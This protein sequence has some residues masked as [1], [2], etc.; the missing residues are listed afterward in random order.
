MEKTLTRPKQKN[1][2]VRFFISSSFQ[3]MKEERE[4]LIKRVFPK[5]RSL[6]EKRGVTWGAVDLRW[7]ITDEQASE[8]Q[9]LPICLKEID[10][11][12]GFFIGILGD[13]Y[14]YIPDEIPGDLLIQEPWLAEHRGKSFTELEICHGV[15]NKPESA[16]NAFFYFRDPEYLKSKQ[17]DYEP[18]NPKKIID[19]KKRIKKSGTRVKENYR[20]PKELGELVFNDLK[21]LIDDLYPEGS[22]LD[23]LDRDALEHELYAYSRFKVYISRQEYYDRLTSHIE[24]E[25]QPLIV[26]GE[27]GS[28]KSALLAN[29]VENYRTANPANL[30][31]THYIGATPYSTDW[32]LMIRRIMGEFKRRYEFGEEIPTDASKLRLAFAN[33]LHMA[34]AAAGKTG[35]KIIII[36]DAL[37]QLEDKDSAPD[38]V[39]LPPMIPSNVRMLLSTLSGRPLDDLMKRDWPTLEVHPFSDRERKVLVDEYLGQYGKSLAEKRVDTIVSSKQTGNP[40]FLRSLLDELRVFG[41]HEHLDRAIEYYLSSGTIP[42][43]YEKILKRIERDYEIEWPGLVDDAMASLWVS[44][45]GLSEEELLDLLGAGGYPLP[46]S[47]WSQFY[48][49]VEHL[50]VNRNGLMGFSHD[51]V[52]QAVNNRYLPGETDIVSARMRLVDY[53]SKQE[54]NPRKVDELPWQLSEAKSW[55]KLCEVLSDAH[56]FKSAWEKDQFEVK[57]YWAKIE[58][59]SDLKLVDAYRYVLD[60]PGEVADDETILHFSQLLNDMGHPSEALTLNKFLTEFY[61]RIGDQK[62]LATSLRFQGNVL[63]NRGNYDGAMELYKKVER[64]CR[65]IG[66]KSGISKCLGNQGTVLHHRGDYDSAMKLYKEHEYICRELGN[67]SG[68]WKSLNNQGDV[69]ENRGDYKGAMELYKEVERICREIGNKRG[70]SASLC[71]Q[72]IV[73]NKQGDSDGAMKLYKEDELICREIGDKHGLL[74]SIGNQG[75][76]LWQRGD[77]DGA[78]KLFKEQERLCRELG[79]KE[80][81]S[82]SLC[83]QGIVLAERGNYDDALKLYKEQERICREL[84]NKSGL[85]INL[86][87]QGAVLRDLGKYDEAMIMLNEAESIARAIGAPDL[88][89]FSLAQKADILLR[90]G[91]LEQALPLAEEANEIATRH[92]IAEAIKE[93]QKI[94][95]KI[96]AELGNKSGDPDQ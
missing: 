9:V 95:D 66:D 40:L 77:Y 4:E 67:K 68:L 35:E 17:P 18:D 44:R 81:L 72:G 19:L 11:C 59:S 39:W 84:G 57:A 22:E 16:E 29:W 55:Q 21:K 12:R 75:V 52:R 38:L 49:A 43:L 86:D 60:S 15:L 28:G 37:N 27:S 20:N 93:S 74:Y 42:E 46:R 5:I 65:E 31:I 32:A 63:E 25:N 48:S 30:Y 3:D 76:V 7:G 89:A 92:G 23:P 50:L 53:F 8:G 62:K 51:Y 58:N 2:A 69:L 14:G 10:E 34:S 56:F 41:T 87:N 26:L 6:C 88:I 70:L 47:Q 54:L 82:K 94:L 83:N 64:I 73:L 96:R 13:R 78:M 71:N 61:R 85:S 45:R 79:N 1:R 90:K 91:L 24:S 36:L 80:G 33:W